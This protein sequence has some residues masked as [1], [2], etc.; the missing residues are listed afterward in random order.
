MDFVG[1]ADALACGA[2]AIDFAVEKGARARACRP[3]RSRYSAS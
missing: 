1:V 2:T 3:A